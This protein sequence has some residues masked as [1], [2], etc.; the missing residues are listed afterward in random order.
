MSEYSIH[1][2]LVLHQ[3]PKHL[4]KYREHNGHTGIVYTAFRVRGWV[5]KGPY[6]F[7]KYTQPSRLRIPSCWV[8]FG[9]RTYA[10]K[11]YTILHE[12]SRHSCWVGVGQGAF[13]FREG[14]LY[15][16]PPLAFDLHSPHAA[17]PSSSHLEKCQSLR[18]SD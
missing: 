16:P 8:G 4:P 13:I 6:A 11:G 5:I 9:K 18:L 2:A 1:A 10:P 7:R 15:Y 3:Q 17:I 14:I 12:Y